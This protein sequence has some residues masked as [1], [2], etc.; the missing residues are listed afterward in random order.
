MGALKGTLSRGKDIIS[1]RTLGMNTSYS[2]GGV[3]RTRRN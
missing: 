2:H 1:S 3:G